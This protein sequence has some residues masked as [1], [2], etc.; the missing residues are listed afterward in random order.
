MV[1]FVMRGSGFD[2]FCAINLLALYQ[3]FSRIGA[4]ILRKPHR[5]ARALKYPSGVRLSHSE[6]QTSGV[7]LVCVQELAAVTQQLAALRAG[8]FLQSVD[9]RAR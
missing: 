8:V 2:S 4:G 6:K 1:P 7:C 3:A 9:G 5:R